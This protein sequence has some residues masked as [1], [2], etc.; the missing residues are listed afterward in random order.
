MVLYNL[1]LWWR[2]TY[3]PVKSV[4]REIQQMDVVTQLCAKRMPFLASSSNRGVKTGCVPA[5]L[6][7]S[8]RISSGKRMIMFNGSCGCRCF[9]G[10]FGC[11]CSTAAV[12]GESCSVAV[13]LVVLL[14]VVVLVLVLVLRDNNDD[15]YDDATALLL[16]APSEISPPEPGVVVVSSVG[17][18]M[19]CCP[20]VML[21]RSS[22]CKVDIER[23]L[24]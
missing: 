2:D 6:S 24:G 15:V 13:V 16:A 12:A 17:S 20:T 14:P 5:A 22:S 10:C 9:G 4:A 18:T 8:C 1:V 3:W 11:C 23:A 21:R 7:E 19:A